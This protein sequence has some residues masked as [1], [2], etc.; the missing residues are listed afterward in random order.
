MRQIGT[1]ADE[2]QAR[3]IGDYLQTLG[4]STRIDPAAEGWIVWVHDE[5]RLNQARSELTTFQATPDDPRYHAAEATARDLRKQA[6]R[7]QR[8]HARQSVYLRDR[9]LH[10]SPRRVPVTLFLIA[11]S[12]GV[13]VLPF[14]DVGL[15]RTV[16]SAFR[17]ATLRVIRAEEPDPA[18][19]EA[20]LWMEHLGDLIQVREGQ[21]WRLV[22]PIF[23]H[24]S[25]L[26]IVFN[27]FWLAELGG[28][29]EMLRKSWR[30]A[31]FVL[32]S[33]IASNL[34]EYLWSGPGFGGMSGVV[35]AL[36][37]HAWMHAHY[38]PA[39]PWR[40]RGNS[41]PIMLIWLMLGMTGI[42]GPIANGAHLGGL[43]VGMAIGVVPHARHALRPW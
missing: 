43:V 31:L 12:V 13:F 23:L 41:I 37:G 18:V 15:G 16:T 21:V 22:T 32:A 11:V 36:F 35:Y 3:R 20:S 14:V 34:V 6:E 39:G 28:Q 5:N 4:I 9:W 2:G 19:W 7:T 30:L 29:F 42:L 27:M 1:I 38:D 40:L 8:E 25:L 17:F 33:G 10:R 24:F 26:H